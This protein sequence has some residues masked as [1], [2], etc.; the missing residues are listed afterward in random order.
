MQRRRWIRG[1][2]VLVAGFLVLW[3]LPAAA[4]V[5]VAVSTDDQPPHPVVSAAISGLRDRSPIFVDPSA[6]LAPNADQ[7][8]GLEQAVARAG[9]PILIAI[10]PSGAGRARDVAQQL[11]TGVDRPGTYVAVSG[12][13][14]EATSDVIDAR[15]LMQQAFAS[16]RNSGTAA[17]LLD[18]IE[19]AADRA[20]GRES[21]PTGPQI[22]PE[23]AVVVV[24]VVA[25]I[26]YALIPARKPTDG[27]TGGPLA[28]TDHSAAG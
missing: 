23:I 22:G 6:P 4:A 1:L 10:V 13:V 5:A 11:R 3:P 17:V 2:V 27:A 21:K 26:A 25:L 15:G 19:L 16:G 24:V 14:Y 7:V 28:R 20:A 8:R 12:E 18:F 9:T